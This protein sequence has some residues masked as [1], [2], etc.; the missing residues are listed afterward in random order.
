MQSVSTS[1]IHHAR[2]AEKKIGKAVKL[3]YGMMFLVR[4]NSKWSELLLSKHVLFVGYFQHPNS[5]AQD[6]SRL[7]QLLPQL[8]DRWLCFTNMFAGCLSDVFSMFI[9]G[10]DMPK[11]WH[12]FR[13]L[14]SLI[15]L[16]KI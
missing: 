16:N 14:I 5:T 11:N 6:I 12:R 15:Y 4:I 3:V 1:I 7:D 10:T 2:V 9:I 8:L 13:N